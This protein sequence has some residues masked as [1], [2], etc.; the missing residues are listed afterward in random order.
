MKISSSI[1]SGRGVP[2]WEC[3]LISPTAE[4]ASLGSGLLKVWWWWS[5][6]IGSIVA[7]AIRSFSLG[8]GSTWCFVEP[9]EGFSPEHI[10]NWLNS[11]EGE[12]I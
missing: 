10:V 3:H 7:I 9:V 6:G 5:V 1:W 8:C 2:G 12:V 4:A 11:S